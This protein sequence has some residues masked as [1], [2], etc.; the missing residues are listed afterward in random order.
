MKK[1]KKDRK[2]TFKIVASLMLTVLVLTGSTF[3]WF[4]NVTN[5]N[6]NYANEYEYEGYVNSTIST[7]EIVGNASINVLKISETGERSFSNN[8]IPMSPIDDYTSWRSG[9][10]MMKKQDTHISIDSYNDAGS[11][12]ID[13]DNRWDTS[14]VPGESV[15]LFDDSNVL[16]W[17]NSASVAG[18]NGTFSFSLTDE[19][20]SSQLYAF[21]KKDGR[22]YRPGDEIPEGSF[23]IYVYL[24]GGQDNSSYSGSNVSFKI[25]YTAVHYEL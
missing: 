15:N 7:Y 12:S 17:S 21:I 2:R 25:Q 23:D 10:F 13:W 18:A 6:K 22:L 16:S 1:N 19:N 3:A 4:T 9:N 11:D 8:L 5:V 14:S 20:P 24:D